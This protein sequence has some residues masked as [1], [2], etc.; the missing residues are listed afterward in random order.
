MC[1]S[2]G[3]PADALIDDVQALREAEAATPGSLQTLTALVERGSLR[4]AAAVLHIHSTLQARLRLHL[5][6]ALRRININGLLP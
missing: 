4:K 1:S 2:T 6:L 5:A 3:T